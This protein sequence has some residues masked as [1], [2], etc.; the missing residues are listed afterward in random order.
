MN[1]MPLFRFRSPAFLLFVFFIIGLAALVGGQAQ[2]QS[3]NPGDRIW[4]MT[5]KDPSGFLLIGQATQSGGK[6]ELRWLKRRDNGFDMN[7]EAVKRFVPFWKEAST[8]QSSKQ[9]VSFR[10]SQMTANISAV[11]GQFWIDGKSV[12]LEAWQDATGKQ[13]EDG[14][15]AQRVALMVSVR[16]LGGVNPA[17]GGLLFDINSF[18]GPI[19]R[20]KGLE[21][22]LFNPENKGDTIRWDWLARDGFGGEAGEAKSY[23]GSKAHGNPIIWGPQAEI[24]HVLVA[25]NQIGMAQ[26]TGAP[27]YPEPAENAKR[28]EK[29]ERQKRRLIVLGRDL[30]SLEDANITT[31][32][33]GVSYSKLVPFEPDKMRA[34]LKKHHAEAVNEEAFKRATEL[35]SAES[36]DI[37]QTNATIVPTVEPELVPLNVDG[38]SQSW[39]LQFAASGGLIKIVRP[40]KSQYLAA[41]TP[42]AETR[43]KERAARKLYFRDEIVI[44]A[45]LDQDVEGGE[46]MITFEDGPVVLGTQKSATS[47][48]NITLKK[49]PG[50]TR[51]YRSDNLVLAERSK[52][53]KANARPKRTVRV[54]RDDGTKETVS[55]PAE[56]TYTDIAPQ[57]VLLAKRESWLRPRFLPKS[58][59]TLHGAKPDAE[60]IDPDKTVSG[61]FI[62]ALKVA[63]R[64]Q[65]RFAE[66]DWDRL[67]VKEEKSI[68]LGSFSS[69]GVPVQFGHHAAML[70]VRESFTKSLS[71]HLDAIYVLAN[72]EHRHPTFADAAKS[73]WENRPSPLSYL[74]RAGQGALAKQVQAIKAAGGTFIDA[75]D[76]LNPELVDGIH[77]LATRQRE[78]MRAALRRAE[79]I[80]DC[81][82]EGLLKLTGR[83]FEPII[84]VLKSRVTRVQST[85]GGPKVRRPDMVARR[86]LDS[87]QE[88]MTEYEGVE[89]FASEQIDTLKMVISAAGLASGI[90]AAYYGSAGLATVALA[91]DTTDFLVTSAENTAGAINDRDNI[92]AARGS[93]GELGEAYL[94][95]AE[96]QATSIYKRGFDVGLSG[97]G[98][99][100]SASDVAKHAD[101]AQDAV[102][103]IKNIGK[104]LGAGTPADVND[105]NQIRAKSKATQNQVIKEI[106]D[107]ARKLGNIAPGQ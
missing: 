98:G 27:L 17:A 32:T 63:A 18:S 29:D 94:S 105:A 72:R 20:L 31:S 4:R 82:V 90:G 35:A 61:D 102:K 5:Y 47:S 64:C 58:E 95:E 75:D 78:F 49:K 81:Y 53:R 69:H 3:A 104:S 73:V 66:T 62:Q 74:A 89:A 37:Y 96:R 93:T 14:A 45:E 21:L 48:S 16:L 1:P 87:L 30:K 36:L 88:K 76:A 22:K 8:D 106:E 65:G 85:G 42:G 6:T 59:I 39:P 9:A 68:S 107:A 25:S 101:K 54:Q 55:V 57:K 43:A 52:Y 2:A 86:A 11:P 40:D 26:E 34:A 28:D 38:L 7:L 92:K 99:V 12:S 70:M 33:L 24:T 23:S 15:L 80:D 77:Q 56:D 91:A 97:L 44:E 67:S 51:I 100:S 46:L 19:V 41:G 50:A 60:I 10:L 13:G 79:G 71:K 103:S 84:S 83:G